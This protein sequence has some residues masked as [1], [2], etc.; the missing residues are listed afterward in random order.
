M[1]RFQNAEVGEAFT[2]QDSSGDRTVKL[3]RRLFANTFSGA[4]S[5]PETFK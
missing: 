3:V 1:E 2:P 4:L 5:F